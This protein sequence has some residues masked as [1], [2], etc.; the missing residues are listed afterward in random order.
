M[1][2]DVAVDGLA[3]LG[4]GA[5]DA[6]FEASLGQAGEEAFHGVEPGA[7]GWGEVEDEAGMTAEPCDDLRMLVGG[8]VVEDEMDQLARRHGALDRIEPGFLK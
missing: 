7:Q 4:D 8:V 3:Q 2:L 5:E 1:R 6:A